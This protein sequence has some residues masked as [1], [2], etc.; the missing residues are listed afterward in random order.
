M[1]PRSRSRWSAAAARLRWLRRTLG[2][3]LR[4]R[5]AMIGIGVI[6]LLLIASRSQPLLY[7]TIWAHD[8]NIYRPVAGYDLQSTHPAGPSLRHLLGTDPLGRDL[9]SMLLFTL[10]ASLTLGLVSAATIGLSGLAFATLGAV[11]RGRVDRLLGHVSDAVL[12]L[13]APIFVILY[14]V[15]RPDDFDPLRIGLIYG[16]LTGVSSA[17]IVLR[18]HAISVLAKPFVD[19]G[20]V[21][22]GSRWHLIRVHLLPHL[23][24]LA[25]IQMVSGVAGVIIA[26]GFVEYLSS[27]T[28]EL[29]LGTMIYTALTYRGVFG[30]EIPWNVLLTGGLAITALAG[31]FH[32]LSIGLRQVLDP[33]L[34]RRRA[35]A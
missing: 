13:P 5:P 29:G 20:R 15:I 35:G 4:N 21:A 33:T 10:R 17:A 25:A 7:D 27:A 24:P 23:L 6:V 18:S 3:V 19:A 16:V 34:Q 28:M 12:L 22:G 2:S 14:G 11:W 1:T 31:S 8:P 32:L 30:T 26:A 9:L